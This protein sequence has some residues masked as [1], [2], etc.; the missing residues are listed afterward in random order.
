MKKEMLINAVH[1]EQKRM[2]IIDGGNLVEFN[3][4][5]GHKEPTMGNVYK[6]IVLK[7]ERGLQAAF[8][9][10][11]MGKDGFL[12]LHDVSS[13]YFTE[14][15]GKE[16]NNGRHSLRPGQEVLVQV[17]REISEHKGAMLT[18]YISLPGRYLVLLPNKQGN[19][20]SRKIEAESE[21]ER[22]KTLVE[23]IKSDEGI[24]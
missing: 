11:G 24:G 1:R 23:Q 15:T 16:G 3:I 13:E 7:V 17:L 6:G 9:N 4:E 5:M 10:Y 21:R 8:V 14:Q 22:L 19:G 2:A 18:T 12:P 20:V